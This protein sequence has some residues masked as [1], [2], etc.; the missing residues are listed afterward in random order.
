MSHSTFILDIVKSFEA[1]VLKILI[2]FTTFVFFYHAIFLIFTPLIT[3]QESLND[4][5]FLS[6]TITFFGLHIFFALFTFI[7]TRLHVNSKL[8]LI[9]LGASIFL[10]AIYLMLNINYL[11]SLN[12]ST[13]IIILFSS[14]VFDFVKKDAERNIVRKYIKVLINAFYLD[15]ENIQF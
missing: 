9:T 14:M 7:S 3:L 4:F 12:I 1:R 11:S 5:K 2:L 8:S 15:D 10:P 6:F 13:F